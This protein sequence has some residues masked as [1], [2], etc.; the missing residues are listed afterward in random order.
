MFSAAALGSNS[1]H[2][3]LKPDRSYCDKS[4][5]ATNYSACASVLSDGMGWV[6]ALVFI[7]S[8]LP[9]VH[10]TGADQA[11]QSFMA[12]IANHEDQKTYGPCWVL[13]ITRIRGSSGCGSGMTAG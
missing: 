2:V 12:C 8:D 10:V 5:F 13:P 11:Y 1:N 4:A 6:L 7:M 3:A 9:G